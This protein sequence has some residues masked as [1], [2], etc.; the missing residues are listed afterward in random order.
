MCLASRSLSAGRRG[1]ALSLQY[2]DF[3]DG[4]IMS[5]VLP[6]PE[7]LAQLIG[8][9]DP[10]QEKLRTKGEKYKIVLESL[11]KTALQSGVTSGLQAGLTA[12]V[13]AAGIKTGLAIGVAGVSIVI[14]PI[15]AALAPWF[16]AITIGR[17]VG[18]VNGFIDLRDEAKQHGA[19]SDPMKTYMCKC[20][21]CSDNI[22]YIVEKEHSRV[23]RKAVY[24]TI[25]GLIAFPFKA[26]HSVGKSFQSGRPKEMASRGLIESALG[27]CTV[28][29]A[30]IC[31]LVGDCSNRENVTKAVAIVLASDGWE[32]VKRLI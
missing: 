26:A 4:K 24:C 27:G 32:E 6:A 28:A 10:H 22:G 18:R 5:N 8:K 3:M 2:E 25:V 17:R 7:M 29:M 12:G 13:A 9:L 30:T 31:Y 20:G 21:K 19:G 1:Y 14:A 16:T 15:G 23:A 11:A